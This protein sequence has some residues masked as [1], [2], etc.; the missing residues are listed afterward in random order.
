MEGRRGVRWKVVNMASQPRTSQAAHPPPLWSL[1]FAPY[2]STPS[3]VHQASP[4]VV[5]GPSSPSR[6]LSA[7]RHASPSS[8]SSF[9]P[10]HVAEVKRLSVAWRRR[11]MI[12][13]IFHYSLATSKQLKH[14]NNEIFHVSFF[15]L[16]IKY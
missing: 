16:E 15:L 12:H 13:R 14:L 11:R 4:V 7:L 9:F 8:E 1:K 6:C 10:S 2:H 3:F 5:A